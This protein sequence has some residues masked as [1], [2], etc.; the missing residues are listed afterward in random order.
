MAGLKNTVRDPNGGGLFGGMDWS[1]LGPMLLNL[2]AGIASGDNWGQ[3]IGSGLA[4]AGKAQQNQQ[5]NELKRML[6]QSQMAPE[7]QD[8]TLPGGG[9][10]SARVGPGGQI[11]PLDTSALGPQAAVPDF[12]NATSLRKEYQ[13]TAQYKTYSE[14]L[15]IFNSMVETKGRNNRAS[16][17]NL[18]YGLA[19]IFDPN[20]VVREGEMV[21]VKD[22]SSL[23]ESLVGEI[24]R[25]NGG[26]ALQLETR[27]AILQEAQSRMVAYQD[28]LR[29]INERY[30][31]IA[32]RYQIPV[33]DFATDL[34]PFEE[35]GA[36]PGGAVTGGANYSSAPTSLQAGA[37]MPNRIGGGAGMI[38]P[39]AV[40]A[41]KT[42]PA[43]REQFE[44]KYG[45]SADAFLR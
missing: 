10:V 14:A 7:V 6:L 43:L 5:E 20:S 9:K 15:P 37:A 32:Q 11:M 3:G 31:G 45:V 44:A 27:S 17:L 28:Q 36:P 38:P 30:S 29:P 13:G 35:L 19:K 23:P 24:N 40:Q 18:V 42:N 21:L 12:D 25:L 34:A 39:Q 22:T 33:S 1:S 41:L 16:D 4:L 26:A 8:I 2:G